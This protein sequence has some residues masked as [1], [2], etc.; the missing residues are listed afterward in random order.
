MEAL[1]RRDILAINRVTGKIYAACDIELFYSVGMHFK[2]VEINGQG[3]SCYESEGRGCRSF[4]AVAIS[5]TLAYVFGNSQ[6]KRNIFVP[7]H[8]R[9]HKKTGFLVCY[10]MIHTPRSLFII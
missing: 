9:I 10:S 5:E 3:I 1:F 7:L 2:E 8:T 6:A 4:S